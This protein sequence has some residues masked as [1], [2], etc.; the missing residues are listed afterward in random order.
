MI[1]S[2]SRRTDIPSLHTKW[3]LN[4]LKDAYQ[5][6]L[7][8]TEDVE[9]SVIAEYKNRF[10]EAINDD[11][12]MPL[13]MSVVWDVA[14]NNVKSKKFADL[15]LDFDQVLGLKLNEVSEISKVEL[16]KEILEIIE[17]R[18]IARENKNWAESDR[19]RDLLNEK[20]YNVKD[21][22]DGM[23]VTEK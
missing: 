3:F 14:K 16:P 12:N 9:D 17:S 20:G 4:R 5:K 1:I 19:L 2:A 15:L 6:H 18:K 11:L 13:A 21:T 22:K 10:L 23:E 7:N 8:G